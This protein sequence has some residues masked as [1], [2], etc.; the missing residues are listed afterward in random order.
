MFGERGLGL[1]AVGVQLEANTDSS[2]SGEFAP[3]LVV[4]TSTRLRL[5][6]MQAALR[7]RP[8]RAFR[9]TRATIYRMEKAQ[10]SDLNT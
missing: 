2:P 4:A 10:V 5:P 3:R 7:S 9:L 8:S 6:I 1:W